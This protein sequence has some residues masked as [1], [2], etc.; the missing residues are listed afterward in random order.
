M[1]GFSEAER[2]KLRRMLNALLE[3]R[4]FHKLKAYEPYPKQAEFHALGATHR[5]RGLIAANRVGKSEC[6]AAETAM[7]LTGQ[8]PPDWKGHKFTRP[9][10]AWAAGEDGELTRDVSQAKL[11]GPP[12][13]QEE[14]GSGYVPRDAFIERPSLARGTTDL[15]D[16]IQVRHSSGGISTLTF[17][18]YGEQRKGFQSA[19]LDWLWLDEEPPEDIYS[20]ATTRLATTQ[21]LS[22]VTFTPLQGRTS[23]VRRFKDEDA[24]QRASVQMGIYD[25]GHFTK[26]QADAEVARYPAHERDAR[27]HGVPMMGEGRV[28]LTGEEMLKTPRPDNIP[29]FWAKIWGIDFGGSSTSSHAFAAALMAWDR[30]TDI[31]YLLRCLRLKNQTKIQHVPAIRKI[32]AN[33][34]VAWPHDG[35]EK[36]DGQTIAEQYKTP[37]PGMLGLAMLPQHATWPDGGFSTEAAVAELDDRC[38]TGRFLV[39]DVPEN[40]VFFEEYRQYHRERG[41]LVKI[42]DDVLSAV[43]KGLMMKRYAKPVALGDDPRGVTATRRQSGMAQDFDPFTGAAI[44]RRNSIDIG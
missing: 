10:R 2:E 5:E 42:D 35:H 25:A 37:L 7:H 28:F 6:A 32:A 33:V 3:V 1:T 13:V 17:K 23:L 29:Q 21:G 44:P 11:C 4:R 16:T 15:Y 43:F 31:L 30:E 9:I 39:M 20:E 18:T 22:I 38:A 19:T 27:A 12:G 26:E 8:Y 40:A 34:P 14:F 24:P 36:R 41:L